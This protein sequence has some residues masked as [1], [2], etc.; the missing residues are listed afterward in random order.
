MGYKK[1]F[2]FPVISVAMLLFLLLRSNAGAEQRQFLI[3][4][5]KNFQSALQPL[6]QFHKADGYDV[7]VK[8][9]E[10]EFHSSPTP[11]LVR[12]SLSIWLHRDQT[13]PYLLLAG[14]YSLI[15]SPKHRLSL[16]G[17]AYY[18]YEL[19]LDTT[20]IYRVDKVEDFRLGGRRDGIRLIDSLVSRTRMLASVGRMPARTA[21]ELSFMVA[22]VIEY[23][24]QRP[25]T[26]S[27]FALASVE[28]NLC[29]ED[30]FVY[31]QHK[32]KESLPSY[33]KQVEFV[34]TTRKSQKE[35]LFN[36]I[37]SGVIGIE[38]SAAATV[39]SI[40]FRSNKCSEGQTPLLTR[41]EI[42][43]IRSMTPFFVSMISN[44]Q[45]GL[46]EDSASLAEAFIRNAYAAVGVYAPSGRTF[47]SL[48]GI[49]LNK[50]Y[51]VLDSARSSFGD[52][53]AA[54]IEQVYPSI[55][56]DFR[57]SYLGDPASRFPQTV[58]S[59]ESQPI[60]SSNVL[61][62]P[63]PASDAA[64]VQLESGKK[65]NSFLLYDILGRVV[66]LNQPMNV[67][68]SNKLTVTRGLLP[69][70]VYFLRINEEKNTSVVKIIFK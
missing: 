61:V 7:E 10:D 13:R 35:A 32:R 58:T 20:I 36:L 12:D 65:Y 11:E 37:Q 9:I 14:D 52:A 22:K 56:Y 4:T 59:N 33:L 44:S 26:E 25:K 51:R 57:L 34:H 3:L 70:G 31:T 49:H 50:V 46:G 23:A 16:I 62:Y 53:L 28:D 15:P 60:V 54:V 45:F 66:Q 6:I 30:I 68:V 55:K 63:A 39:E 5:S 8:Y 48:A 69:S 67:D 21:T 17:E 1:S 27:I 64:Y 43:S 47:A 24:Q 19:V 41:S 42:D 2:Q 18:D 29:D 40:G 38:F